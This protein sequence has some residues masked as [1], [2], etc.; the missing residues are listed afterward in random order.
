MKK[1][2]DFLIDCLPYIPVV[3]SAVI[4]YFVAGLKAK[5]EIRKIKL[6]FEHN[7][8]T[9]LNEAFPELIEKTQYYCESENQIYRAAA[10]KANANYICLAKKEIQ[11]ALKELDSALFNKDISKIKELRNNIIFLHSKHSQNAN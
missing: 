5:S 9:A 8:I 11:P 1:I 7:N 4:S 10:I 3:L 6:T 2:L